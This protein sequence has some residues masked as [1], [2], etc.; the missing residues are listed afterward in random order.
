MP[1]FREYA[2]KILSEIFYEICVTQKKLVFCSIITKYE[3]DEK[4]FSFAYGRFCF[5]DDSM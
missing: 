5:Y 4:N 3:T 1:G 2:N